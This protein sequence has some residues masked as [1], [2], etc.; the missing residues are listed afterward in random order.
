MS[1]LKEITLIHLLNEA[2]ENLTNRL[3]IKAEA[4]SDQQF[5]QNI[6]SLL[7]K[8]KIITK[9]L[10]T[11]AYNLILDRLPESNQII[12]AHLNSVQ[13][14]FELIEN[15]TNSREFNA[16]LS[17]SSSI[18]MMK[19]IF[20]KPHISYDKS[21]SEQLRLLVDLVKKKWSKLGKEEP[22]WS[23]LA[24]KKYLQN[25]LNEK[26][27]SEFFN[28]NSRDRHN[29]SS[30]ISRFEWRTN[31]DSLAMEFGCG[32]G[33]TTSVLAE[34][35][36]S[37]HA[38][39]VSSNHLRL[40][41]SNLHEYDN[42]TFVEVT[43]LDVIDHHGKYDFI[44]SVMVLQHNPPPIIEHILEKLLKNL[45]TSGVAYI[46]IPTF[47]KGYQYST[48]AYLSR[49]PVEKLELHCLP[50]NRVIEIIE[51]CGCYLDLVFEDKWLPDQNITSN[52]FIIRRND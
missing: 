40:A 2:Q 24:S 47:I 18:H 45:K 28:T 20:E 10:V 33:R 8:R 39:D 41:A 6:H 50:Q 5:I 14:K 23:V 7:D 4:Y 31:N 35:F 25:N 1:Q 11:E 43:D 13:N 34:T 37:V 19:N 26:S 42:I 38:F 52:T 29:I 12:D 32:I 3:I 21:N 51:M 30:I 27:K 17:N 48:E 15:L 49:P 22:Y 46:Q 9:E 36:K 44:Y 16:L